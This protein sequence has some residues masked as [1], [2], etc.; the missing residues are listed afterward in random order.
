MKSIK[1]VNLRGMN[2]F[3]QLQYE[4]LLLR[5]TTQNWFLYNTHSQEKTIVVGFSGKI[6]ELVNIEKA[7]KDSIKLVRRFTG[8]G[9]VIIDP[10]TIFTSFIVDTNDIGCKPYPRDIMTWSET[11]FRPIFQDK[12][13][14]EF[15]LRENDY[16][17]HD[18]KVGGNAQSITRS[19]FVHHTSFLYSFDPK[20]MDYLLLPKKRP[21]Y[22]KDR[23]HTSFLTTL[24]EY[25]QSQ[26]HLEE[27]ILQN[28]T[29]HFNVEQVSMEEVL[30][31]SNGI[32]QGKPW[33]EFTRTVEE[34]YPILT[35][36]G[37]DE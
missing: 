29:S 9:T 30:E 6:P 34:S 35:R 13:G 22:R 15:S 8:G 14:I 11:V 12:L 33:N 4:E 36:D 20:N 26:S 27:L 19:R 17:L 21:E 18:R 28:L 32:M 10:N 3:Q 37:N 31:L 23:H 7:K 1:C 24:S 5:N 25:L 2:I 16:V